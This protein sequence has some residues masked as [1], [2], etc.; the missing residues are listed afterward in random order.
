M[1]L[2]RS[3]SGS[4]AAGPWSTAWRVAGSRSWGTTRWGSWLIQTFTGICC[5]HLDPT[6]QKTMTSSTGPQQHIQSGRS[7]HTDPQ[8][9]TST[10]VQDLQAAT[11]HLHY[12]GQS[13][14]S[15]MGQTRGSARGCTQGQATTQRRQREGRGTHPR[16]GNMREGSKAQLPPGMVGCRTHTTHPAKR[17]GGRE[18]WEGQGTHHT[19]KEKGVGDRQGAAGRLHPHQTGYSHLLQGKKSDHCAGQDKGT[20]RKASAK[21]AE[22]KPHLKAAMGSPGLCT[23]VP[24]SHSVTGV[25][26]DHN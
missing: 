23:T 15:R 18:G 26:F 7:W 25:M 11:P 9:C 5:T 4:L 2:V 24:E 22:K 14:S 12:T 8:M 17:G 3:A 1:L 10:H 19:R 21:H 13:N 6:E 20:G 16:V